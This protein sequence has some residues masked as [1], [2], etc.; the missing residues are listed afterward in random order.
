MLSKKLIKPSS[1]KKEEKCSLE[2]AK[3]VSITMFIRKD[4]IKLLTRVTASQGY[5]NVLKL[6]L[7]HLIFLHKMTTV[8][9]FLSDKSIFL[10]RLKKVSKALRRVVITE[11][12]IQ[13]VLSQ[14]RTV[15]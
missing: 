13:L 10:T 2:P 1:Y 3:K 9:S 8:P 15:V 12:C 4:S 7:Q 11:L 14:W 5:Q 6:H